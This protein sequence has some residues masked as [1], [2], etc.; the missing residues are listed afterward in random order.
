MKIWNELVS[1]GGGIIKKLLN[2]REGGKDLI[3]DD[4]RWLWIWV[5]YINVEELSTVVNQLHATFCSYRCMWFHN[6]ATLY[7]GGGEDEMSM[8]KHTEYVGFFDS[9]DDSVI[10]GNF[11]MIFYIFSSFQLA[12]LGFILWP[13][14]GSFHIWNRKYTLIFVWWG[15]DR[16]V[17]GKYLIVSFSIIF[18]NQRHDDLYLQL[19][20]RL[21]FIASPDQDFSF[22]ILL[23]KL[24]VCLL[25]ASRRKE[26]LILQFLW[27]Q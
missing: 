5:T 12:I 14:I 21:F 7:G 6:V 17:V 8:D 2:E 26:T 15:N 11:L 9:R 3:G 10:L 18:P 20:H 24:S 4:G 19:H 16:Y 1:V 13:V 25:T 23:R 27:S 22:L